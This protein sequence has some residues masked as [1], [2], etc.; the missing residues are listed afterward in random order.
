MNR[1]RK[2]GRQES[3]GSGNCESTKSKQFQRFLS[4]WI[5]HFLLIFS[6]VPAALINSSS[7]A[8][9][10]IGL[11]EVGRQRDDAV[12]AHTTSPRSLSSEF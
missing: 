10:A 6:C 11:P 1:I 8:D 7:A 2:A 4:S 3:F 12:G 5:P 9:V